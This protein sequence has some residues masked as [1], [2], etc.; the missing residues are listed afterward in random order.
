MLPGPLVFCRADAIWRID[1]GE[2][3]EFVGVAAHEVHAVFA[4]RLQA[5]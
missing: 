2:V 3:E 5:T 1:D 4:R